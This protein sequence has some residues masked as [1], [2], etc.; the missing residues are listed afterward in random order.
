MEIDID[1]GILTSMGIYLYMTQLL[2][3][4]FHRIVFVRSEC[5][6]DYFSF[7]KIMSISAAEFSR[8]YSLINVE[9]NATIIHVTTN[10]HEV[11][12]LWI[13]IISV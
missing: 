11:E 9:Y 12:S 7:I 4:C 10:P 2:I 8:N 13:I 5:H 3:V 6:L 1:C